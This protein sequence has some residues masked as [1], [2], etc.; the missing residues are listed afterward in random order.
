ML[1][2]MTIGAT[3]AQTP[4]YLLEAQLAARWGISRRSLQ[5]WRQMQLG[6][7]FLRLGGRIIYAL[8]D[9][10]AFERDC[11]VQIDA[12]QRGDGRGDHER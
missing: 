8:D 2:H 11:R 3:L 4:S 12:T 5:R 10:I 6:P 9:V 1:R 7:S